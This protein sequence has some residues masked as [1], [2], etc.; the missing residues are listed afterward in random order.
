MQ[1]EYDADALQKKFTWK[2]AKLPAERKALRSKWVY[3]VKT[4]SDG[5][6]ERFKA[7]LM[8]KGFSQVKGVDYNE[9]YAT[10][11]RCA[12][13]RYLMVLAARM[14]LKVQQI[15]A[16]T[17]FL[18]G[19]LE[20]EEIFMEQPEGFVDQ[21]APTKVCKLKKALYGLEQ[22]SRVWNLKLDAELKRIGLKHDTCVYFKIE[23]TSILIV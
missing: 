2:L 16:T 6:V 13:V 8:I 10:V 1:S 5:S 22:A 11:V 4:N 12:T 15:A 3:K 9:T 19:D 14:N 20:S 21:Q 23:G 17:A 7:R 18:Q